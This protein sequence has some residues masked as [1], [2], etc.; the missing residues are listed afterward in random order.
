MK[1]MYALWGPDLDTGLRAP[2]LRDALRAGGAQHSQ[3]VAL[4][5]GDPERLLHALGAR[6]QTVVQLPEQAK[7]RQRSRTKRF[8]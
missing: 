2:E 3:R 6:P 4:G 8:S 7:K 1:L 5:S